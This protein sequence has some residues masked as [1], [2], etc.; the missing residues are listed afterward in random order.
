MS[1][2]GGDACFAPEGRKSRP[3]KGG[4]FLRPEGA[5]RAKGAVIFNPASFSCEKESAV[6]GRKKEWQRGELRRNKLHLPRFRAG[7]EISSVPLFLLFPHEPLRWVRAGALA[8]LQSPLKRPRRGCCP[9][10]NH[11]QSLVCA[12]THFKS[13]KRDNNAK[14][15]ARRGSR[16]T[17]RCGRADST[18]KGCAASVAHLRR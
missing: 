16:N 9:F 11:F 2:Q 1:P 14:R 12:K 15:T 4:H 13:A 8:P 18:R 10:L 17:L 5:S 7:R 3:P 6:D